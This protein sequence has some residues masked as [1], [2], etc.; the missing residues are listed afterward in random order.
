VGLVTNGEPEAQIAIAS[1]RGHLMQ[2]LEALAR[3]TTK[4]RVSLYQQVDKLRTI[5]PMGATLVLVS[6]TRTP[7]LSS[8]A[9]QLERDGHS[10]LCITSEQG[11]VVGKPAV[12]LA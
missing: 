6:R 8:L 12:A 10:L 9:C 1:G 2:I 5:T 4:S 11:S 7:A 3:V